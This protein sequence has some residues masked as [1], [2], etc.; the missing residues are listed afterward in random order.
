MA[1]VQGASIQCIAQSMHM[2]HVSAAA[3]EELATDVEYRMR[4]VLQ[5]RREVDGRKDLRSAWKQADRT[6]KPRDV[7]RVGSAQVHE[8]REEVHLDHQRRQPSHADAQRGGACVERTESCAVL[9]TNADRNVQQPAYGLSRRDP[10]RFLRAA[11]HPDVYYLEDKDMSMEELI[12]GPMPRPLVETNVVVHWLAVEGTQ[13]KIPEN[14]PLPSTRRG[15]RNKVGKD[16]GGRVTKTKGIESSEEDYVRK[17]VPPMKHLVTAEMQEY[18]E[19]VISIV[20]GSNAE[21]IDAAIAS[22][23]SD[24][25]LHPLLP[26]FSQWLSDGMSKN[27][28]NIERLTNLLRVSHA[29][30]Q[31]KL[32]N[33]EPYLHQFMPPLLTCMV[34]KRI[35]A[36]PAEDHW[37]VRAMAADVVA[38]AVSKFGLKYPNLQSRITTT[39]LKALLDPSKPLTTHYGAI[40]GLSALGGTV[41]REILLPHCKAY[42]A[43]LLDELTS[44]SLSD[45]RRMEVNNCLR[46]LSYAIGTCTYVLYC[47]AISKSFASI[48]IEIE[49][50]QASTPSKQTDG[51]E[52]GIED[53]MYNVVHSQFS[54]AQLQDVSDWFGEDAAAFFPT[55]PLGVFV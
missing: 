1:F 4:E 42:L 55:A 14:E 3:E 33:A 34:A 40:V 39:L 25:G 13:P 21:K 49:N 38:A 6:R 22:L 35:G 9:P 31:N 32:L 28:K 15:K 46:A 50:R 30:L 29:L 45:V 41:V 2:E 19:G 51:V 26:Y 37:T 12:E 53:P 44:P 20:K 5:V 52:P 48:A 47:F 54:T 7:E 10:L 24:P 18:M 11:G 17:L 23:R 36:H 16:A 27:L 8:A 43:V